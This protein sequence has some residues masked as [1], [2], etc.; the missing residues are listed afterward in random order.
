[1][2]EGMTLPPALIN[3]SHTDEISH[4][5]FDELGRGVTLLY[6]GGTPPGRPCCC[7]PLAGRE[8]RLLRRCTVDPRLL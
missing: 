5:I 3:S 6:A 1:V 8:G 2:Q 7:A 4:A